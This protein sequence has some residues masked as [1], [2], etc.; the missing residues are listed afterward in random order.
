MVTTNGGVV[1][2]EID[3]LQDVNS[4]SITLERTITMIMMITILV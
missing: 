4:K 2:K 1:V 3:L